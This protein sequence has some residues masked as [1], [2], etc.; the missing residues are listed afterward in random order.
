MFL[1]PLQFFILNTC[2]HCELT[3]LLLARLSYLRILKT[4]GESGANKVIATAAYF[5]NEWQWS[6]VDAF[7]LC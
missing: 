2:E 6:I 7:H 5:G 1:Q 3:A 4:Y